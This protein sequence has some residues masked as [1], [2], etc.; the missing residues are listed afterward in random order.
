MSPHIYDPFL[1]AFARPHDDN[2]STPTVLFT[3]NSLDGL[4]LPQEY[5][6]LAEDSEC[7]ASSSV[8]NLQFAVVFVGLGPRAVKSVSRPNDDLA[9]WNIRMR[10]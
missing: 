10:E 4:I 9:G 2:R 7:V 3:N 6:I 5:V 1:L 8:E